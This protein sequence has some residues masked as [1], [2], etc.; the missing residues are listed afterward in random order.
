MIFICSIAV[1]L[2]H[3]CG[4]EVG[5]TAAGGHLGG[6]L[7][8][9]TVRPDWYRRDINF[10][11]AA[12]AEV[13]RHGGTGN[14]LVRGNMPIH[15]FG[16]EVDYDSRKLT[17]DELNNGLKSKIPGFDLEDYQLIEISLID[18]Q[19]AGLDTFIPAVKSFGLTVCDFNDGRQ[20]RA[21]WPP[22]SDCSADWEW[23]KLWGTGWV[24]TQPEPKPEG[25]FVW[26]PISACDGAGDINHPA[27]SI[28]VGELLTEARWN[29]SGLVDFLIEQMKTAGPSAKKKVLYFHCSWGKDRT[30]SLAAAYLLKKAKNDNDPLTLDQAIQAGKAAVNLVPNEGY[31]RLAVVYCKELFPGDP[32]RC[33]Y[34]V[35]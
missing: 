5:T 1:A 2:L 24:E 16:G 31:L 12:L 22:K 29:F 23:G 25:H 32:G 27:C 14:I 10:D 19:H 4:S 26:W 11:L 17:Y 9:C 7:N 13:D 15:T 6:V 34:T 3:A 18:D 8:A 28:P 33:H 35:P 30:G 21:C 20:N